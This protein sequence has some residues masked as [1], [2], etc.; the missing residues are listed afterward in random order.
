MRHLL[1]SQI[2][3]KKDTSRIIR[4]KSNLDHVM[5]EIAYENTHGSIEFYCNG[6]LSII[7]INY[8]EKSFAVES[9]TLKSIVYQFNYF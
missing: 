4:K 1:D 5:R 6:E 8:L 2:R 9:S 7:I 3:N